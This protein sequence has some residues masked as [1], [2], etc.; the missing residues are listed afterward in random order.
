MKMRNCLYAVAGMSG[1]VLALGCLVWAGGAMVLP[2]LPSLE[3]FSSRLAQKK[4]PPA[5]QEIDM[6][7][8]R[9]TSLQAK[10]KEQS[11]GLDVTV[12]RYFGGTFRFEGDLNAAGTQRR[13]ES[14]FY[15]VDILGNG[16]NVSLWPVASDDYLLSGIYK[17]E[18]G[19]N[20]KGDSIHIWIHSFSRDFS[21]HDKGID[22]DVIWKA[23]GYRIQG[24]IDKNLYGK[25]EMAILGGALAA[26]T[27]DADR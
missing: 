25:K 27:S 11:L 3:Q 17:K 18:G 13:P 1:A 10:V 24:T 26:L 12:N 7:I 8:V 19:K 15:G 16:V 5:P 23:T 2:E 22:L 6:T 14:S 9:R 4:V 21:I 20:K